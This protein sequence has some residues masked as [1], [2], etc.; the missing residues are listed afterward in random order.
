MEG[1]VGPEDAA[2]IQEDLGAMT[3]FEYGT[4]VN[5]ENE[6]CSRVILYYLLFFVDVM[7]QGFCHKFLACRCALFAQFRC[8]VY[9]S[10]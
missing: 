7:K 6:S 10:L 3:C 8:G 1:M 9:L 4:E 5:K 2:T